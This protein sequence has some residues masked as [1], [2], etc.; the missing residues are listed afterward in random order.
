MAS[1]GDIRVPPTSGRFSDIAR[2]RRGSRRWGSSI[3]RSDDRRALRLDK[4]HHI[5]RKADRQKRRRNGNQLYL[6][7]RTKQLTQTTGQDR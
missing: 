6:M 2:R 1:I 3:R 5:E 7:P 4:K